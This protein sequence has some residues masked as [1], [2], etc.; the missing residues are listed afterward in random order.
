MAEFALQV[1]MSRVQVERPRLDD[2]ACACRDAKRRDRT[3]LNLVQGHGLA[4]KA[5]LRCDFRRTSAPAR[6]DR[7]PRIACKPT[8]YLPAIRRR[9]KPIA[10]PDRPTTAAVPAAGRDFGIDYGGFDAKAAL[11]WAVVGIPIL[12][13][14]YQTVLNAAKIFQ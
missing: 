8:I 2:E 13:G 5:G 4:D 12:W 1:V 6:H 7:I 11:A 9:Q 10:T 14:V 3:M